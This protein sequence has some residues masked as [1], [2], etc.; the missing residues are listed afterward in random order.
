MTSAAKVKFLTQQSLFSRQTGEPARSPLPQFYI[1][2][3]RYSVTHNVCSKQVLIP[4]TPCA[5]FAEFQNMKAPS[6]SNRRGVAPF[7]SSENLS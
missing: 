1:R 5:R 7:L 2:L 4:I 6:V 3:T